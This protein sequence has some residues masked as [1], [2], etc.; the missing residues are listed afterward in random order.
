MEG[1]A[2]HFAST[3]GKDPARGSTNRGMKAAYDM[4]PLWA[5]LNNQFDIKTEVIQILQTLIDGNESILCIKGRHSDPIPNKRGLLQGSALS[6]ILFNFYIDDLVRKVEQLHGVLTYGHKTSIV[7]FADDVALL[8]K[9]PLDLQKSVNTAHEWATSN[10]MTFTVSKCMHLGHKGVAPKLGAS[11]ITRCDRATYLGVSFVNTGLDIKFSN[12]KRT[13]N[14]RLRSDMLRSSGFNI[15]GLT[16]DASVA[17]NVYEQ[18]EGRT[19]DSK[20][21]SVLDIIL[22]ANKQNKDVGFYELISTFIA[23]IQVECHGFQRTDLI[24][25]C[26]LAEFQEL[27]SPLLA[28]QPGYTQHF[29]SSKYTLA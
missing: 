18:W 9:S 2:T 16:L 3:F 29:V 13:K 25:L 14:A 26:S 22:R 8:A 1:H 27:D 19:V 28:Y 12:E 5:K 21:E 11:N 6:P 4:V 20:R 23:K 7:V 17:V 24:N 15:M 10:V